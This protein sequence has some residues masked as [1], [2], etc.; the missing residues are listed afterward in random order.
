MVDT[1]MWN[2][3]TD[4][5]AAVSDSKLTVWYCPAAAFIDKDLIN[6]T[7]T[8]TDAAHFGKGCA[9]INFFDTR[10]SVRKADGAVQSASIAAAPAFLHRYCLTGQWTKAV[11]L[12]RWASQQTVAGGAGAGNNV[13][14]ISAAAA[15]ASGGGSAGGLALTTNTGKDEVLWSTLAVLSISGQQLDTAELALSALD[16]ID[17]V[18]F[19][20]YIKTVPSVEGRNAELLL[21]RRRIEDAESV[22]LQSKL[23]YRAI[24]LNLRVFRWSRALDLATQHKTHI[25]T[26]MYYR[27]RYLSGAGG[28]AETDKRFLTFA[29]DVKVDAKVIAEKEAQE[30]E[31]EAARGTPY[32]PVLDTK[33]DTKIT[34][35]NPSSSFGVAN[36]PL[37]RDSKEDVPSPITRGI[38]TTSKTPAK[39]EG[40]DAPPPRP[41]VKKGTRIDIAN[42]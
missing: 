5:L 18:H 24:S 34:E 9:F 32:K 20:Q 23:I 37:N 38:S 12:C 16:E 2:D 22:L 33:I 14:I 6:Y 26:V 19:I 1:A 27:G 41:A 42:D 35:S 13:S 29:A 10:L 21:Y 36:S 40:K 3:S 31:K 28:A 11:R 7:R 4:I 15:A 17:K 39:K 25:D 8:Q 30:L